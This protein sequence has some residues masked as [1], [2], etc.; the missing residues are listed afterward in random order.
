[1]QVGCG[2]R[3]KPVK[4]RDYVYFWRYETRAGQSRQVY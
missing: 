3:I 1:M 4:G 2:F